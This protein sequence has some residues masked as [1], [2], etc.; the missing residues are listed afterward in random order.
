MRRELFPFDFLE[1][2]ESSPPISSASDLAIVRP[3]P[4]RPDC[5]PIPEYRSGRTDEK[6]LRMKE[7][8]CH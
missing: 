7:N 6:Y 3:S 4:V 5:A 8:M 1:E 2:T